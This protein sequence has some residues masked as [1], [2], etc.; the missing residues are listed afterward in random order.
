[1]STQNVGLTSTLVDV[2]RKNPEKFNIENIVRQIVTYLTVFRKSQNTDLPKH[3]L[4][5]LAYKL[6][7]QHNLESADKEKISCR[8]GCAFCCKMNVDVTPIE[9]QYIIDYCKLKGI[10]INKA[11]LQLQVRIPK[12]ELAFDFTLSSCVF[13]SSENICNIYEARPLACRKYAVV[14]PAERCN[15]IKYPHEK[16]TCSI[17]L[18]SEILTSALD[19]LQNGVIDSLPKML[20]ELL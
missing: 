11:Y 2:I 12:A 13:L 5:K 10:P 14:S 18:D 1:M 17:N 4:I 3:T 15:S 19:N 16:I 9:T 20:L 8:K 7:D 6:I